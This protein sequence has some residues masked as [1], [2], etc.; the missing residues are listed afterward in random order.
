MTTNIKYSIIIPYRDREEHLINILPTLN[1]HFKDSKYEIIVVEQD[2]NELF[3]KNVLLNIGAL[4]SIGELL[5]FHDVD[6]IPDKNVNY[7]PID[8]NPLYV[9][10]RCIFL[11]RDGEIRPDDDIPTGYR[12]FKYDVGNHVG[13]VISMKR[14]TFFN[15]NGFNHL[16]RGW[17]KE[18]H[19]IHLR[20]EHHGYKWY[21][22]SP[23]QGLM[24]G[25]YHEDTAKKQD[26]GIL[27]SN[28]NILSNYQN[29]LGI[30]YPEI[31]QT[32]Q[33]NLVTESLSYP[34]TKKI[35]VSVI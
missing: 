29:H 1:N 19:D 22:N 18:D 34:N 13:A 33:N 4:N 35:K 8:L 16:Y 30:G 23:D 17:G 5:I 10:R 12:N 31:E 3:A 25:L 14:E 6:F 24:F 26:M 2:D 9:M 28:E 20:L 15:V 32:Y 21:R 7:N 27:H 11:T